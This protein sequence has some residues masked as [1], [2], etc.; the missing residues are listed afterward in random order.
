MINLLPG[1][2]KQEIRAAR[3]NVILVRYIAILI[4]AALV[5]GGL[6]AGSYMALNGTK[7]TAEAKVA[8]NQQRVLAYQDIKNR[9][10]AFRSELST[11]KTILDSTIS[12]SKLIYKIA[13]IVPRNVILDDLTLDPNTFGSS[14]TMTANAKTFND[15]TKLRDAFIK[16]DQVFSDVRL[17]SI[18]SSETS[19]DSAAY[20]VKVSLSVII[21]RG[22]LQ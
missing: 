15:A 9:S 6:V 3:T 13:D 2:Y 4:C 7:S 11:A 16:N 5:L 12:F 10:D 19:A 22:A 8:E 21:N 1:E 18:K 17:Q 20:P 14:V